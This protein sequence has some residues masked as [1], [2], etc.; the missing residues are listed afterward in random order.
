[1]HCKPWLQN[2]VDILLG[3]RLLLRSCRKIELSSIKASYPRKSLVKGER[4]M[5][6]ELKTWDKIYSA[7]M[8]V[9]FKSHVQRELEVWRL[10]AKHLKVWQNCIAKWLWIL[11]LQTCHQ[12]AR[13]KAQVCADKFLPTIGIEVV[14]NNCR[15]LLFTK[16]TLS[17]VIPWW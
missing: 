1:M 10:L 3:I 9:H 2:S 15:H 11:I 6:Y 14:T 5:R 8:S 17:E 13:M 7:H 16:S 12:Q 4:F